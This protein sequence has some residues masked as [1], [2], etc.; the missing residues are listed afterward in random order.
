MTRKTHNSSELYKPLGTIMRIGF[1]SDGVNKF[2]Y[3]SLFTLQ[4]SRV[5]LG[6]TTYLKLQKEAVTNCI[7]YI[8]IDTF[9][10][11]RQSSNDEIHEIHRIIGLIYMTPANKW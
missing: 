7:R 5:I 10:R 3:V 2:T 11:V 6:S 8:F 9:V 1:G 4:K